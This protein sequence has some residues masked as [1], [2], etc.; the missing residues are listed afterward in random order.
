MLKTARERVPGP[1]RF[2]FSPPVPR[3]PRSADHP[4]DGS[5]KLPDSGTPETIRF[6]LHIRAKRPFFLSSIRHKKSFGTSFAV[7]HA[8]AGMDKVP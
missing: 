5:P 8:T 4:D 6:F 2:R 1:F 3:T 7:N